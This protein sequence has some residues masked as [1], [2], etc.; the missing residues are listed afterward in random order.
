MKKQILS[1]ALSALLFGACHSI[2]DISVTGVYV[3]DARSEA[4]IAH[5]TL[6]VEWAKDNIYLLHR[7]TGFQLITKGKPGKLLLETEEWTATKDA[8]SGVYTEMKH[9]KQIAFPDAQSMT[10]GKRVYRRIN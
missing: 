7:H 5:D 1:L 10:V 4:S 9:G 6:V 8:N 2:A 3:N